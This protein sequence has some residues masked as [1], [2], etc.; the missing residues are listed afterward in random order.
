MG[1]LRNRVSGNEW[2]EKKSWAMELSFP[3]DWS[4]LLRVEDIG[5]DGAVAKM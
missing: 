4:W 1:W 3:S 2:M 5:V